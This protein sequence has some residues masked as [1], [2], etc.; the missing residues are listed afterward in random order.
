MKIST[1][2]TNIEVNQFFARFHYFS[3]VFSFFKFLK[4]IPMFNGYRISVHI[5]N[6]I[7]VKLSIILNSLFICNNLFT[8]MNEIYLLFEISKKKN[9]LRHLNKCIPEYRNDVTLSMIKSQYCVSG[10]TL[11]NH[12]SNCK[13]RT[14]GG[15]TI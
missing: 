9:I 3:D 4:T 7:S 5:T 8:H 11:I 2:F 13:V 6:S 1:L 10:S 12:K 15:P 14:V